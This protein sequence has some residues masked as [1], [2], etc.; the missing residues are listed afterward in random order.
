M[1]FIN[2]FDLANSVIDD[3]TEQFEP[4]YQE[5][6]ELRDEFDDCC[7][8]IDDIIEDVLA[9]GFEVD[10]DEDSKDI[11]VRIETINVEADTIDAHFYEAVERCKSFNLSQ[12]EKG[13][14]VVTFVFPGVWKKV[15]K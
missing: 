14:L 3:A 12:N 1:S 11:I 7:D 5:V 4:E 8:I 13:D 15:G 6:D 2:F 10:V 9:E